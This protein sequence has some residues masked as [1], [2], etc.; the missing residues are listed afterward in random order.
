MELRLQ[1]HIQRTL[2]QIRDPSR[3]LPSRT[4]TAVLEQQ[5]D[6][7]QAIALD[8]SALNQSCNVDSSTPRASQE[9]LRPAA[10][11]RAPTSV[12]QT[13][14]KH[15]VPKRRRR[16]KRRPDK[17]PCSSTIEESSSSA[18]HGERERGAT[19]NPHHPLPSYMS[20]LPL[21]FTSTSTPSVL[22]T[23]SVIARCSTSGLL[24]TVL[25]PTTSASKQTSNMNVASSRWPGALSNTQSRGLYAGIRAG[26]AQNPGPATHARDWTVTEQP[27]ATHRRINE[28]GD[29]VPSSQDSVT[30]AI[31]NCIF[32]TP[33]R[34]QH[35][36]PPPP[37]MGE[38]Q[39]TATSETTTQ[40]AQGVPSLR[41][42]W[43]RCRPSLG[44]NRWRSRAAHAAEAR[45]SGAA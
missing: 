18:D 30:R 17:R 38:F 14:T 25:P 45:K 28:A 31:Q 26:E 42:V 4:P 6:Q 33:L 2:D 34:H 23:A 13:Q 22:T 3:Q 15:S 16:R 43:P 21:P 20:R 7:I 5:R 44:V 35:P 1:H 27:K 11:R 29:S 9:P 10:C 8:I 32:R 36:V 24:F 37:T 39:K 12:P 40:G 19:R 41:A